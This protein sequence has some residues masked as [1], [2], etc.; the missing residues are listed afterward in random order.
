MA[1]GGTGGHTAGAGGR[2]PAGP[3]GAALRTRRQQ[4]PRGATRPVFAACSSPGRSQVVLDRRRPD[5]QRGGCGGRGRPR[6]RG[7]SPDNAAATRRDRRRGGL[8]VLEEDVGAVGVE[9][10]ELV[11]PTALRRPARLFR[12]LLQ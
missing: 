3:A 7:G 4:P 8:S 6:T 9:Q 1:G 12:S 10:A 11:F 5:G 2:R